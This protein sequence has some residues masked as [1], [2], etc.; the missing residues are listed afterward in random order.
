M[1]TRLSIETPVCI[2]NTSSFGCLHNACPSTKF[3]FDRGAQS[4]EPLPRT[5]NE[6]FFSSGLVPHRFHAPRP[7]RRLVHPALHEL[8]HHLVAV[9]VNQLLG[10]ELLPELLPQHLR[11]GA[12][13][14]E[15]NERPHV[16]KHRLPDWKRE[17][18]HVLMRQR[19][20]EPILARLGQNRRER[21]RAEVLEL[22]NEQV[23]IAA[24]LLRLIR[25]R[26]GRQLKLRHEER[27]EQVRLVVSKLPLGQV[28]D[29]QPL[30]VH[31]ERE[32]H[33]ALH[34]PQDVPNHGIQEELPELVLD[35]RDGLAPEPVVVAG[36][37]GGPVVADEGVFHLAHHPSSVVV[38]GEQAVDAK[39]GGVRTV[40][41]GGNGV[42]EDVFEPWPPRIPPDALERPHDAGGHQVPVILGDVRKQVQP[43]GELEVAGVEVAEVVGAGRQ[44]VVQEVFGQVPVRVNHA[45]PI[46]SGDVLDDEV[47]EEGRLAHA[48]LADHIHVLA[49]ILPAKAKRLGAFPAV[50]EAVDDGGVVVHGSK[51]SRHS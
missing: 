45:H 17:L 30:V 27:P 50:P 12:P 21:I 41:K 32:A 33:F 20:A 39:Q 1:E 3:V 7:K 37:F 15:G 10:G 2:A 38:V 4:G 40:Q 26:H 46:A 47:L 5:G 16:P 42:V 25:P 34:L 18:V 11:V 6:F 28:G 51:A 13:D 31:D 43:D 22:V 23:E 14:T 44:D 8:H 48:G 29:K 49:G 35:G 36:I 19:Q 24:R 9:E